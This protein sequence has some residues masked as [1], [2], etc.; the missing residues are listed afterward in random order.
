MRHLVP[1]RTKKAVLLQMSNC[2]SEMFL[3]PSEIVVII[4]SQRAYAARE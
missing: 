2:A 4:G 3:N 1:A